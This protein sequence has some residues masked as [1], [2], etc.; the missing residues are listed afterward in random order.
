MRA[1]T[2][3][4]PSINLACENEYVLYI[5]DPTTNISKRNDR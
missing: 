4:S 3:D 1:G 5:S 2:T